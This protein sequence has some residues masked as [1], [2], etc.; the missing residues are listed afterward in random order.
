MHY[1]SHNIGE[2][3]KDTTHLTLLEHGIY[4]M[5]IDSYYMN[6]GPL[7]ANDATLMRT[8][9]V[10]T[11]EERE[12]YQNV[13]NDFFD[14]EDGYYRHDGCDKVL[15]KIFEKSLKA[16]QS[17]EARWAKKNKGSK[18]KTSEGNANALRTECEGDASDMLPNYPKPINPLTQKESSSAELSLSEDKSSDSDPDDMRLAEYILLNVKRV[19]P[20]TRQP[21]LTKWANTI[22]LMR[23]R[24]SLTREE[25]AQVFTWANNNRFWQLN[26]L[27]P[28]KLREKFPRLSAEKDNE[29]A[30]RTRSGGQPT[31]TGSVTEQ[32]TVGRA[33]AASERKR[34]EIRA[35]HGHGVRTGSGGVVGSHG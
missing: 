15:N 33:A 21:N 32:S 20:K 1:Y 2:Y 22:R 3:R 11:A 12:A 10:R 26:I 31:S 16:K 35:R 8:H 30:N 25:I 27:S 9:C 17:A 19:V 34:Q 28:D 13:I 7:E 14:E 4:R 24:D 6:E 18:K 29:Y 23:E 5:L